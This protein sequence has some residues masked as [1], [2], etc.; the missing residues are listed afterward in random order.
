M[1]YLGENATFFWL[2]DIKINYCFLTEADIE[3]TGWKKRISLALCM[4]FGSGLIE[5]VREKKEFCL[6]C[7]A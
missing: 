4:W 2:P 6:K 1:S 5:P 3:L 7:F